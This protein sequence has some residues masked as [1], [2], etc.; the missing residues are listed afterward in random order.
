MDCPSDG[1]GF[2]AAFDQALSVISYTYI[3]TKSFDMLRTR[4]T[5][6]CMFY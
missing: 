3:C 1:F 5:F 4:K 2:F 6:F